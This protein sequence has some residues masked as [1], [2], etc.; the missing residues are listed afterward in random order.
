MWELLT[1]MIVDPDELN[2][3]LTAK[4][5]FA[6]DG[7]LMRRSNCSSPE[8]KILECVEL[9]NDIDDAIHLARRRTIERN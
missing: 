8:G 2:A 3:A 9:S 7:R 1:H 4:G 6:A 5:I